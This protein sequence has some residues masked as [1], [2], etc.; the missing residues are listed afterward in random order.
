MA[1]VSRLRRGFA[2]RALA[3]AA[4][5]AICC[6]TWGRPEES[7]GAT[8]GIA[9][10][11]ST[12]RNAAG[13]F[14][15]N[16]GQW[17]NQARYVARMA[18]MV[19][20]LE[21]DGWTVVVDRGEQQT[22]SLA[23]AVRYRLVAS[24]PAAL[25]PERPLAGSHSYLLGCDASRWC[26]GV[27]HFSAV[28]YHAAWPGCD[29]VCY[30]KDGHLE[31][32]VALSPA[33]DPRQIEIAVEGADRVWIDERG[34]LLLATAAGTLRQP[35]PLTWE[36]GPGGERREV[37]C[38]HVLLG[39]NRFGFEIP[40]WSGGAPLVIDP[41]LIHSTYVGGKD[42]DEVTSITVDNAGVVTIA[43]ATRSIDFPTTPGAWDRLHRGGG[44][45]VF[46]TRLDP[47]R[48]AGQ[49]LL[50]S[51]FLGGSGY[52]RANA[53]AVDATGVVTIAGETQSADFPTTPSA[54]DRLYRDGGSDAF[55]A[56]LDPARPG[57]GQLV[58]SSYLSARQL[59]GF[60][61]DR[62]E[63]IHVDAAGVVTLA[64][65]TDHPGWP[66]TPNVFG[67]KQ[68]GAGQ[69]D[70]VVTVLDLTRPAAQQILYSTH[71]GGSWEDR[72]T[73]VHVDA[74]GVI[75]ITGSTFSSFDPPTGPYFP[76]V[77][78]S[79]DIFYNGGEDGFVSRLDPSKTGLQ[80]LVYSTFVGGSV[81][82]LPSSIAIADTGVITIAG[83][84][85]S[86]DFPTT[87]SAWDATHNGGFFDAFV[88]QL[89][90][91]LP[92]AQQLVYSTFVGG[93]GADHAHAL[94]VDA[95]GV[96]TI[97][98]HADRADYPATPGAFD[99]SHNG[100][101]D[102]FVSRLDLSRPSAQQMLYSTF[103]GGADGDF[104]L[105]MSVD[106]RGIVTVAGMT[107]SGDFPTTP[108]AWDRSHA[109]SGDVFVTRLDLLPVGVRSYGA[110]TPGCAGPVVNGVSSWPQVGNA[111]FSLTCGG[112]PA[113]ASGALVLGSGALAAP[114]L[115]WGA[116]LWVD[117][118][119]VFFTAWGARS[120]SR[121]AADQ[122]LPI[123]ASP[124]LAGARVH[125][126]W[127]WVGPSAPPPCPPLGV[128]SSDALEVTVQR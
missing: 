86:K 49:Q 125:V 80:Q 4:G 56:R 72:P 93:S 42:T 69:D 73:A 3:V 32:D 111:A 113:S 50:W 68:A 110:S 103:L 7:S 107:Q 85:S 39:P 123:P 89:D 6:G 21:P 122:P 43:G 97:S 1:P 46:V 52:D 81:D 47:S 64:G 92:W 119:A 24:R 78:G 101:S 34:D 44:W 37:R 67:P 12:V 87:A 127:L 96:V 71:L 116:E 8:S 11:N 94:S 114:I 106:A 31:Y 120:D 70:V 45:D 62:I 74:Q 53:L 10:S 108:D 124:S 100:R 14:V 118:A 57:P 17:A 88:A 102:A 23:A 121:G 58:Y 91:S 98:G 5:L 55:V 48:P 61:D 54:W 115:L 20:S 83:A 18:S 82:D 75:T 28:R 9:E 77:P 76:T 104:G 84:T 33:A 26:S 22:Q 40:E 99:A 16:L 79:W 60:G 128:S 30:E 36:I 41:G 63:A 90:P 15:P 38:E 66:T 95:A 51:T 109:G 2:A 19:V 35:R 126:Q 27:P 13:A 59:P 112:A 65:S 117:P 25:V 105:A 29:L